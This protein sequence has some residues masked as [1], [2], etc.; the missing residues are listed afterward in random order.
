MLR[1][2]VQR[3]LLRDSGKVH[4]GYREERRVSPLVANASDTWSS[5]DVYANVAK[6]RL[7]PDGTVWVA[8][9]SFNPAVFELG[10]P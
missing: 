6:C 5:R 2:K 8:D 7:E 1:V 4:E 9:R 3:N 10:Q